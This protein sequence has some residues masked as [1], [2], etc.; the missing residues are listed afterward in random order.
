M[1]SDLNCLTYFCVFF[2]LILRCT[3]TFYHPVYIL[4]R[5]TPKIL[6]LSTRNGLHTTVATNRTMASF[7]RI[8]KQV[9][10]LMTSYSACHILTVETKCKFRHKRCSFVT[11]TAHDKHITYRKMQ[12]SGCYLSNG[13]TKSYLWRTI[14]MFIPSNVEHE[15]YKRNEIHGNLKTAHGQWNLFC[16]K[17]IPTKRRTVPAD[18][19]KRPDLSLSAVVMVRSNATDRPTVTFFRDSVV[20]D[21]QNN[22]SSQDIA[23]SWRQSCL[24]G[25]LCIQQLEYNKGATGIV[26]RLYWDVA[27]WRTEIRYKISYIFA[28]TFLI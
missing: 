7:T 28:N 15:L 12:H 16:V 17:A 9:F 10:G 2:T 26:R 5:S 3:E 25:G 1:E 22:S 4:L 23:I 11:M 14:L 6:I 24:N 21:R 13:R 19:A 8:L 18:G 20:W 27:D